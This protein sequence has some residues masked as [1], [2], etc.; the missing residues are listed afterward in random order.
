MDAKKIPDRVPGLGDFV[1]TRRRANGLT[2][3]QL[4]ELANVG[5]RF[6]G[7]VERGKATLRLDRVDRVLA[8]FG[9][10]LG[11]AEALRRKDL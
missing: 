5:K 1:R 10:R 6:V 2:Q 4:A 3:Q 11:I 9:K 7:E 8:V